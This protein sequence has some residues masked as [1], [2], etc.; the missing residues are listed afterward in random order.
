MSVTLNKSVKTFKYLKGYFIEDVSARPHY[1]NEGDAIDMS[2]VPSDVRLYVQPYNA[3]DKLASTETK[4]LSYNSFII[5]PY[6]TVALDKD[7]QRELEGSGYPV[8]KSSVT[9]T[10]EYFLESTSNNDEFITLTGSTAGPA[11]NP[12]SS[13]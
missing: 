2:V 4:F 1:S 6:S 10:A 5:V 12:A 9:G 8:S 7:D 13:T 11:K 3:W